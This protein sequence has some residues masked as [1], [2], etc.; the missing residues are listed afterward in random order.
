MPDIGP[1]RCLQR[2]IKS[3]LGYKFLKKSVW[4]SPAGHNKKILELNYKKC[5]TKIITIFPFFLQQKEKKN[6]IIR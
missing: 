3:E 1:T 6:V 5:K 4:E 2:K